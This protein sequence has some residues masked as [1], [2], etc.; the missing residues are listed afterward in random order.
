MLNAYKAVLCSPDFLF[1]EEKPGKL[2]D[3][4]L[5]TRLSYFLWRTSPDDRLLE[6]ADKGK[7]RDPSILKQ[8]A[9]RMIESKKSKA[10]VDDFLD[11]WLHLKDIQATTPDRDLYPEYFTN[12][13]NNEQDRLLLYSSIDETKKTF[14]HLFYENQNAL[15]MIDADYVWA[16][17]RLAEFYGLPP[18]EGV[19]LRK[20]KLPEDSVRGGVITQSSILKV[21]ANGATTSPVLRGVWL[22]ENIMGLPAPPPPP[23]AGSIEPDTRGS[24]TIREQLEKHMSTKSCAA[25]HRMIDPPGFALEMFDPIGLQR[26]RYRSTE[27]GDKVDKK[28]FHG[29]SYRKVKY[30]HAANVDSSAVLFSQ[31]D[32]KGPKEFKKHLLTRHHNIVRCL[33]GKLV[34]FGTGHHPEPGDLLELDRIVNKNRSQNYGV[35]SL[36]LEIIQSSLFTEK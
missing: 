26:D 13:F 22:L 3:H 32:F 16:N 12:V 19:E 29:G 8:E 5:A 14:S 27:K 25:C 35:K 7:L 15:E 23:N 4:A 6:L 2:S 34:T 36:I 11:H 9:L 18:I 31:L 20:V 30:K 17:K 33:T 28:Y 1:I 21:T 24:T 10:F